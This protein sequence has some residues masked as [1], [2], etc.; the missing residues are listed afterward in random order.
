MKTKIL[1]LL[2]S[3][4]TLG[5]CQQ[6]ENIYSTKDKVDYFAKI[7][8]TLRQSGKNPGMAV[9]IIYKNQLVFKEVFGYRDVKN[10]LPVTNN[11]LFEIASLTK[12]FTGVI[13]SQLEKQNKLNWD[14]KVVKYLPDFKLQ[15][16]YA[17]QNATL[18]D[19][20][21]HNVGL[22]QHFYMIYGPQLT[23]S[24][25]LERIPFLSFNGSFR[26]NFLYNNFMYAVAGMVEERVTNRTWH[27]LMKDSIFTPLGMNHSFTKFDDFLNYKD[28]TISYKN[29]GSTV[30]PHHGTSEANAPSGNTTTSTINDMA[31]WAKML[32]NSGNLDGKEFLTKKQFDYLTSP[33][34]V[35]YPSAKG[36]YGIGWNIDAERNVIYHKGSSPGQRS[37]LTFQ[38]SEGYAIVILTNQESPLPFL[39]EDYA[40]KIFLENDFRRSSDYEK[41][42]VR[43]ANTKE[44][45][46]ETYTIKD[47]L[48]L[49]ELRNLNGRYV[50]PAYGTIEI[51]NINKKQFSFKYYGFKGSI[52]HN[53]ELEFTAYVDHFMGKD[54]FKF[55]VLK[56]EDR[57]IV[58]IEVHMPYSVP[59]NFV[60]N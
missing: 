18:K 17:T 56:G 55:R 59:L 7:T 60:K 49:E 30:I 57:S 16:D 35:R 54:K 15:D 43:I 20:F 51:D 26:E 12:A 28:M 52:K 4:S 21:T 46:L 40:N 8:D 36:F 29:D 13:A 25:L 37:I 6:T 50:H 23:K 41:A 38:P 14:D 53:K 10:R 3:V 42:I 47:D 19:L 2:L 32:A 5:F 27:E 33:F 1:L 22:A 44:S 11:T 48:V 9:A 58:G 39:L 34:V 24:E 45:I 31:I